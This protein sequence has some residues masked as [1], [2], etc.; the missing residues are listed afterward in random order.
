MIIENNG[1]K[2]E[3]CFRGTLLVP[4]K[5]LPSAFNF[6][7]AGTLRSSDNTVNVIAMKTSEQ[8][9]FVPL[10]QSDLKKLREQ[11]PSGKILE[12]ISFIE[13]LLQ[14]ISSPEFVKVPEQP[15]L[16][17]A[18]R[19]VSDFVRRSGIYVMPRFL[20]ENTIYVSGVSAMF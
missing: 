12:H 2:T 9:D 13:N 5:D 6:L 18:S 3:V 1:K 8:N 14:E 15:L 16:D 4:V 7:W 19:L 10:L 20:R 17:A 11:E